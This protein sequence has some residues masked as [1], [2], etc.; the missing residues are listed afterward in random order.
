VLGALKK[1]LRE[2]FV[3]GGF[4]STLQSVQTLPGS[5]QA[6]IASWVV[7]EISTTLEAMR[8]GGSSA[9]HAKLQ[10]AT[11][12]RHMAIK[13]GAQDESHPLWAKAALLESWCQAGVGTSEEDMKFIHGSLVAWAASHAAVTPDRSAVVAVEVQ[14]A[15]W[16]L[17]L[18]EFEGAQRN[19]ELWAQLVARAEGN[20]SLA[21]ARYLERRAPQLAAEA[22]ANAVAE[23]SARAR[24]ASVTQDDIARLKAHYI[25]GG[26]LDPVDI[27]I[28]ARASSTDRALSHLWERFR[29][30]TLLHACARAGLT[31][32]ATALLSNGADATVRNHKGLMP[33]AVASEGP[34]RM[35]LKAAAGA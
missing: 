34:L 17:A 20:E 12:L 30:E 23:I 11:G 29:G 10:Y 32:E 4:K 13:L 2:S 35:S 16:A 31:D 18:A 14:D 19:A 8:G 25:S 24:R 15:A 6:D 21:K 9:I 22:K 27:A 26:S 5:L 7:S 3:L 28:L 33:Y 1:L